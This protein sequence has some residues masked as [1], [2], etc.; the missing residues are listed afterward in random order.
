MRN[1][2]YVWR[3]SPLTILGGA[4]PVGQP[5]TDFLIRQWSS[6]RRIDFFFG[7]FIQSGQSESESIIIQSLWKITLKYTRMILYIHGESDHFPCRTSRRVVDVSVA[8][9]PTFYIGEKIMSVSV[10][11]A[12]SAVASPAVL[13]I[14]DRPAVELQDTI[15]T[16]G[17]ETLAAE[18]LMAQGKQALDVLDSN[19]HDIIKGASYEVF[20]WVRDQHKAGSIDKGKS[21]DAAQKIWERQINRIGSAF[22][23]VKPKS[24]SKDAE[25][26]AAKRAEE[27]AKLAE[28]GDGELLDLRD[29]HLRKGDSKSIAQAQKLAKELERRNAGALEVEKTQRKAMVD[30]IIARVKDLGKAGTDDADTLLLSVIAMLG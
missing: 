14:G 3:D 7:R 4:P 5:E 18:S 27:I 25:R 16:I 29:A 23:F 30:K 20:M 26:K 13:M 12:T 10:T 6:R 9:L 15:F 19:L 24:E 1:T 22:E 2:V 11:T 28:F 21:D 8:L 17:E